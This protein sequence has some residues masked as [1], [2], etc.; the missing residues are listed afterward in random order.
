MRQR[1][2]RK[3]F[4]GAEIEATVARLKVSGLIDDDAFAKAWSESR[5]TS[6]PRSAYL[7]KREL[8]VRGVETEAAEE[9]TRTLDDAEAAYRAAAPRLER[10]RSLPK[11]AARQKLTDFLRRRGFTWTVIQSTLSRL[12]ADGFSTEIDTP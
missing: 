12:Q 5:T 8:L 9:A 2:N 7:V 3:G 10:L 1:L 4:A 6:S 11:E